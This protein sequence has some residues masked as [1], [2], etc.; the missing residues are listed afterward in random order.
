VQ[1]E[2]VNTFK[3]TVDKLTLDGLYVL[4]NL[5]HGQFGTVYLVTNEPRTDYYAL[6]CIEKTMIIEG[7]LE[8]HLQVNFHLS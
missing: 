5:G 3:Q 4:K 2:N 1:K 6:K 7:K 8:K